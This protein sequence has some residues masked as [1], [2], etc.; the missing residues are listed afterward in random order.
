MLAVTE[1]EGKVAAVEAEVAVV[2]VVDE[3][4]KGNGMAKTVDE[5]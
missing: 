1:A 3:F 2:A 4:W 5:K